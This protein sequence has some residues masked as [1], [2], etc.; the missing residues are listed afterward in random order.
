MNEVE[1]T[2]LLHDRDNAQ[3]WADALAEA[4]AELL[5]VEIGEHSRANCPWRNAAEAISEAIGN[6]GRTEPTR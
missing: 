3:G 1:L 2:D 4:V 5:G 6:R